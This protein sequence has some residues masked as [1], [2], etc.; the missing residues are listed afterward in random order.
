MISLQCPTQSVV[1]NVYVIK[2]ENA[3]D[4]HKQSHKNLLYVTKN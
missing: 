4:T 2:R 3:I 1:K